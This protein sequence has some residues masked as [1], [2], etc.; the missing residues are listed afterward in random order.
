MQSKAKTGTKGKGQSG[1][2]SGLHGSN[3]KAMGE[4]GSFTGSSFAD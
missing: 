2:I 4:E 3:A 1:S